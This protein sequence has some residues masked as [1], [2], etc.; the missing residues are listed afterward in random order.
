MTLFPPSPIAAGHDGIT[1]FDEKRHE[2]FQ[3]LWA[4]YGIPELVQQ[5]AAAADALRAGTRLPDDLPPPLDRAGRA[6]VEVARRQWRQT[7]GA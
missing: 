7:R 5:K 1:G 2:A 3:L 4:R 6:V